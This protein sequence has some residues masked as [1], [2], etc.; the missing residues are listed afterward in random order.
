MR[1]EKVALAVLCISCVC[2]KPSVFER[3][4]RLFV[5]DELD[6]VGIGISLTQS[7][8]ELLL[9]FEADP[10]VQS[11]MDRLQRDLTPLIEVVNGV[12]LFNFRGIPMA[13]HLSLA[14]WLPR[15]RCRLAAGA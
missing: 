5:D 6:Q 4:A 10:F 11:A 13:E 7:I 15:T 2:S 3:G 1:G 8:D 12:A 14:L 9:P